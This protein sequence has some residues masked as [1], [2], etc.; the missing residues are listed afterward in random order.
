MTRLAVSLLVGLSF[1]SSAGC[2]NAGF[3]STAAKK[4]PLIEKPTSKS[5]KAAASTAEKDTGNV[6]DSAQTPVTGGETPALVALPT[7]APDSPAPAVK[8]PD[9]D[10]PIVQ[11]GAPMEPVATPTPAIIF[12]SKEEGTFHIGDGFFEAGSPCAGKLL[13]TAVV[14]TTFEFRFRLAGPSVLNTVV[15]GEICGVDQAAYRPLSTVQVKNS[16]GAVV[17]EVGTGFLHAA[18]NG[19][20]RAYSPA[21]QLPAGDYS[22]VVS[23]GF[24]P[25]ASGAPRGDYDD[26]IIGN[27]QISARD[28]NVTRLGIIT[29]DRNGAVVQQI[30]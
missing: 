26:F 14:G 9:A 5:P 20:S 23:S 17:S 29:R 15:I 25:P 27:I 16:T 13:A 1:V 11:P 6:G 28:A 30:P 12:G 4:T 7:G 19:G 24:A 2:S 10:N 22:L 3:Q 21:S 8:A 18:N